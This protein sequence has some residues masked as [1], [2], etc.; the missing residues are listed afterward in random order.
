MADVTVKDIIIRKPSEKEKQNCK[1]WPIWTCQTSTFDWDYTDTETCLILEGKV[2]V[3]DRPGEDSVSFG[4]GDL[5]V[6]PKDL[7][8][9]WQVSEP[10][11]KHY[12]FG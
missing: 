9:I 7:S 10:V 3:K 2:T 5:V 12:N 8:C 11:R 4:V 6:L 1:N